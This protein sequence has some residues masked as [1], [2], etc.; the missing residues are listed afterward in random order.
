[1]HAGL[2]DPEDSVDLALA[3]V[4]L[5]KDS[6]IRANPAGQAADEPLRCTHRP[7][8]PLFFPSFLFP[9]GGGSASA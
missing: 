9:G 5:H 2:A 7:P 3:R 4:V 1:M 6:L 8:P